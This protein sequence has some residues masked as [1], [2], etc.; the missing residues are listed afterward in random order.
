MSADEIRALLRGRPVGDVFAT[1]SPKFK[2]LGLVDKELTDDDRLRLMRQ[3]PQLIR[4]P[5]VAVGDDLV[6]GFDAK[7]LDAKLG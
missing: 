7:A 1:R 6:V 2:E 4:R 3:Y 5:I